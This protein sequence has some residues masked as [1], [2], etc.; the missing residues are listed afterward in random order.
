MARTAIT[1]RNLLGTK[2]NLYTAGAA[3]LTMTAA[4]VGNKQLATASGKDLIFV[5]NT[6]GSP[7]T[8]TFTSVA[9]GLGRTGDITTYSLAAGTVAVFGPFGNEGW[10]QP[11]GKLYFE[12]SNAAVKFAVIQ[13]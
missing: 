9:D 7:S 6:G 1:S 11:D 5:E 2:S 8:V 10:T 13:L 4:D 3:D 12:A